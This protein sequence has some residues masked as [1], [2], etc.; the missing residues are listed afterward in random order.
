[1]AGGLAVGGI[2][3]SN[4]L[5]YTVLQERIPRGALSRVTAYDWLV[6]WLFMPVGYTAAGPLSD[7]VG[8]DGTLALAAGL[9]ALANCSMLLIPSVRNLPRL[10]VE[11]AGERVPAAPGRA[12]TG[13]VG[14][15]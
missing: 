4:V 1:V 15:R 6:S 5:W 12:A 11:Q 10:T 2:A 7:A 13:R 14:V 3:V 9:C 8:V